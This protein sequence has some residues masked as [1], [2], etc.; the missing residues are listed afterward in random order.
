MSTYIIRRL[1]AA[2]PVLAGVLIFTFMVT[3]FTPG[4]PAEIMA[5][6]EASDEAI[7]S[8]RQELGLNEPVPTQLIIYVSNVLQGDL[9]RSYYLGRDVTALIAEALPR[10][11]QLAAVALLFTVLIGI[12]LG[13]ISAVR[14][15]SWVDLGARS[16]ALLGVSIPP[17]FA[18]L[19]AILIFS[20]YFRLFPSFGSGTWQHL[21]LPAVTLALFSAGLVMRLTR[22]AMLEV[23]NEN[24]IRT[25]RAKGL[26]ERTTLA[27][28]R[29]AQ[30]SHPHHHHHGS[31]AR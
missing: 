7:G 1:L 9:G 29:S 10:T 22:S 20:H 6:L 19:L 17:F 18:G 27:A 5:G 4:D 13:I 3:R 31:P 21:V 26:T 15:D 16:T 12:P 14:K 25:A 30:R 24:Y 2:I 28:S 23:L 8:I 11:A